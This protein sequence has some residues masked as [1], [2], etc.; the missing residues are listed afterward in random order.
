MTNI[1]IIGGSRF[2]GHFATDYALSRGHKITLFNRGISN[3]DVPAG[4][5]QISGDRDAD[6]DRLRGGQWDAVIDT[7]GF[8]PRIVH[9]SAEMLKDMVGQY[10]YI[11][12]ISAYD[13]PLPL[14]GDEDAPLATLA[15]PSVEEVTGETYGG[16][17]VL[18]E[19]VVQE[20]FG[21]RSTVVRPGLI[22]GPRDQTYRFNY[23]VGRVARGGEVL[24]PGKPGDPVQ[25]IDAR[26]LGEWLIRLVENHTTGVFNATGPAETLGMGQFLEATCQALGADASFSWVDEDFVLAHE[27]QPWSELPLWIPGEEASHNTVSVRRAIAA[28]LTYRPLTETI[29]STR[30]WMQAHPGQPPADGTLSAEKE[31]GILKEWRERA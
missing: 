9:K 18:C 22:V 30:E 10:L 26:D 2:S 21:E 28:G 17:K 5:E 8:V 1:L 25:F 24:S 6:I 4:A 13:S 29:R 7:C 14:N 11:S 31:A 15:D 23:W 3:P 27:V 12:S 16:L 20:T 19:R